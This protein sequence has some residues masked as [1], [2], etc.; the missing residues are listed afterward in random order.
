MPVSLLVSDDGESLLT[1]VGR[2]GNDFLEA[3]RSLHLSLPSFS[4]STSP[5]QPLT[6]ARTGLFAGNATAT[7]PV[8][9]LSGDA[10]ARF[11]QD[12]APFGLSREP[13]SIEGSVVKPESFP[14]ARSFRLFFLPEYFQPRRDKAAKQ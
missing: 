3:L 14:H 9:A 2:T 13:L 10:L 5:R 1:F 11:G 12:L 8:F 6:G 4:N 7:M